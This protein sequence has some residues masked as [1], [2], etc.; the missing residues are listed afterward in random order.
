MIG[1]RRFSILTYF[2]KLSR[3]CTTYN[4]SNS[5]YKTMYT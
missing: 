4:C 1:L 2:S 5:S 3:I